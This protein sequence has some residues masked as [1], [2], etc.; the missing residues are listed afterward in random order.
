[1]LRVVSYLARPRRLARPRTPPF[2]GDN[3]GSNPVGDAKHSGRDVLIV[4]NG[5]ELVSALARPGQTC[6]TFVV[7]LPST[8][9]QV[10]ELARTAGT[11]ATGIATRQGPAPARKP[12]LRRKTGG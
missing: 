7:D 11:F 2:H 3:T 8:V 10:I 12:T 9:G 5:R 6:L 4:K 1:M